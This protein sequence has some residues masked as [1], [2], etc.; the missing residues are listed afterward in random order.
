MDKAKEAYGAVKGD[1]AKSA[2]K[3]RDRQ[4]RKDQGPLS[5]ITDNLTGR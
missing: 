1:E 4:R 5:G 2:E 3:E